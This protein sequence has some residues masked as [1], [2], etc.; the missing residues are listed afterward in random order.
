M[1]SGFRLSARTSDDATPASG[2]RVT[3]DYRSTT[4]YIFGPF[5]FALEAVPDALGNF[6]IQFPA[7]VDL[8]APN[9]SL[10]VSVRVYDQDDGIATGTFQLEIRSEGYL[11]WAGRHFTPA[12]LEDA[13]VSGMNADLTGTGLTNLAA[14][15]WGADPRDASSP[16]RPSVQRLPDGSLE[17]LY[18]DLVPPAGSGQL[19]EFSTDLQTWTASPENVQVQVL[20]TTPDGR[21]RRLAAVYVGPHA[22]TL[23][24]RFRHS[25]L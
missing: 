9:P 13:A 11:D 19:V 5:P 14:Y 10:S 22:G 1:Q 23:V 2:L 15:Y 7:Q 12:E 8:Y 20:E 16:R 24:A 6:M 21:R 3:V 25:T 17:V 18:Y 4:A